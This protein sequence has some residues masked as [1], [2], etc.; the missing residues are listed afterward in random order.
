MASG[1]PERPCGASPKVIKRSHEC[2]RLAAL[3]LPRAFA[4]ARSSSGRRLACST[5]CSPG[6]RESDPEL[7]EEAH[8]RMHAQRRGRFY[9]VIYECPSGSGTPTSPTPSRPT[10]TSCPAWAS[11]PPATSSGSLGPFPRPPRHGGTSWEQR[12]EHRLTRANIPGTRPRPRSLT[13]PC[14]AMVAG[15]VSAGADLNPRP[16][17]YE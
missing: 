5:E 6:F 1:V 2:L 9:V 12:E 16:S 13:G 10:S 17:G 14:L 7:E 4:A 11:R 8:E 3:R 15:A